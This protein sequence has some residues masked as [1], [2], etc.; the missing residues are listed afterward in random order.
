MSEIKTQCVKI[1]K[2]NGKEVGTLRNVYG[3]DIDMKKW[4]DMENN[5]YVGRRGRIFINKEIFHYGDSIWKNPF[6]LSKYSLEESLRLYREHVL[7]SDLKDRLSELE[8]KTLGCFCD[9]KKDC[10]AKVLKELYLSK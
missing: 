6:P 10:H 9:Q 8:G 1:G 5:L 7:S 3:K 4:M 2:P